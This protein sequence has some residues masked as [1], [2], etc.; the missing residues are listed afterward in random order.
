MIV[1][2]ASM[3]RLLS[4]DVIPPSFRIVS[5]L[6]VGL[7]F[8]IPFLVD[9]L[10]VS[11][12][13]G[14]VATLIFPCT[15]VALE[16]SKSLGNGSWGALAYTQYGNL[17]LMQLA[18]ITGIWGLSFL[19]TWFASI[20]N[21]AW[22]RQFAWRR[23]QKIA[24]LYLLIIFLVFMYGYGRLSVQDEATE[25]V[26]IGSVTNQR[27]FFTR[28][29]GTDWASRKTALEE[30][31]KDFDHFSAATLNSAK[32]GSRIVLW[33]EYGICV[34][35][36]D[37]QEFMSRAKELAQEAQVYLVLAIGLFPMNYLDQPWQ[38]KLVWID[39]AGKVLDE[40][41][42][43][44]P[45]PPLEPI[46]AGDGKIPIF[47]TTHGRIASA[48][49]ADLDYP[50]LIRQAGS[51]NADI[52]L[53]PAQDWEAVDPLHSHM[54]VFRAI[55]NGVSVIKST[56]AGLSIAVTPYGRLINASEYPDSAQKQMVSCVP[57]KGIITVYS[58]IGDAFAWLCISGLVIIVLL[59]YFTGRI[60]L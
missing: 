27:D 17:P 18:S 41:L 13:P 32:E 44:K 55:E 39:P 49:C 40:Y 16:Y 37:E 23:V 14:W 4:I 9:R 5:G 20:V 6:A 57:N 3:W 36:E 56:G 53:I 7:I 54:A 21:F 46:V 10:L 1:G 31:K 45:A 26:C 30:T 28:F 35:E 34:R 51:G 60:K 12:V 47:D 19:I 48:I 25:T 42:K 38:N 29:Y 33:Q 52:L 58:R 15:W 24:I 22:E 2:V 59:G 50:G 8:F 11:K 43:S